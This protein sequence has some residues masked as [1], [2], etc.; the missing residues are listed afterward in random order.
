MKKDDP[1]SM[2]ACFGGTTVQQYSYRDDDEPYEASSFV[3]IKER[4]T[5]QMVTKINVTRAESEDQ[6]EDQ[7]TGHL[8]ALVEF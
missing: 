8:A 7:L 6:F 5:P 2:R 3:V 1:A 4:T